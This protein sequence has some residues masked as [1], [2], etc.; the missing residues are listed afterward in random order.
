MY[1]GLRLFALSQVNRK[2]GY[3]FMNKPN[4]KEQMIGTLFFILA[5]YIFVCDVSFL[6]L[7]LSEWFPRRFDAVKL[8]DSNLPIPTMVFESFPLVVCYLGFSFLESIYI[9][10]MNRATDYNNLDVERGYFFKPLNPAGRLFVFL[11]IY[12]LVRSAIIAV[13]IVRSL[14]MNSY[15]FSWRRVY[16]FE[17]L[18]SEIA[19]RLLC[20]RSYQIVFGL[21]YL[22]PLIYLMLKAR[23]LN[24]Q[25][26]E[27]L[28]IG[29]VQIN[30]LN[31]KMWFLRALIFVALIIVTKYCLLGLGMEYV[32]EAIKDYMILES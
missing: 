30:A 11:F 6:S 23:F 5:L 12:F 31:Y 25:G 10:Q 9:N 14:N 3:L 20:N 16:W 8:Y 2:C 15:I 13:E 4:Q 28:N 24:N 27:M 29:P 26:S 21:F 22:V 17:L 18:E 7:F 1:S 32:R 19:A